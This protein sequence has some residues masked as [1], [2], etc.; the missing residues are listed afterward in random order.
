[1]RLISCCQK[2]GGECCFLVLSALAF[3]LTLKGSRDFSAAWGNYWKTSGPSLPKVLLDDSSA[4]VL[5]EFARRQ[6]KNKVPWC[7]S[8]IDAHRKAWAALGVRWHS[9]DAQTMERDRNSPWYDT[10]C[11]REK[12]ALAY[13]QRVYDTSS[14]SIQQPSY[15]KYN[16]G[17][18][19]ACNILPSSR[20]WVS[21][22]GDA[23]PVAGGRN[24]LC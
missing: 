15:G 18:L 8:M 19:V 3:L 7:S 22:R 4:C 2:T 1:M 6:E 14:S 21:M 5:N 10:L 12:D 9:A 13:S 16:D 24:T 23:S 17:R 11:A 20:I